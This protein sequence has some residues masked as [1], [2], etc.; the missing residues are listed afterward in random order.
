[1]TTATRTLGEK[2]LS[3]VEAAHTFFADWFT[4]RIWDTA[5]LEARLSAFDPAFVRISPEGRIVTAA[6]LAALLDRRRLKEDAAFSIAIE[7]GGIVFDGADAA[8]VTYVERQV[9]RGA[10]SRRRATA[11]F[12]AS[13]TAPNGVVWRHLQ[14]T[15]MV[16]TQPAPI[17]GRST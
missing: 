1:M 7:D 12:L 8:L 10:E 17:G 2:A 15:M 9:S 4:G 16:S 6:D 3:E 13:P 14:E 5:S 11:L